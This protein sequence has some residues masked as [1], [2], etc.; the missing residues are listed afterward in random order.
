[1]ARRIVV[2]VI[3]LGVVAVGFAGGVSSPV[4]RGVMGMGNRAV[5]LFEVPGQSGNWNGEV[6]AVIPGTKWR[7]KSAT[8]NPGQVVVDVPGKGAIAL[9]QGE[10]YLG[11]AKAEKAPDVDRPQNKAA[12]EFVPPTPAQRA[13]ADRARLNAALSRAASAT[14]RPAA[15]PGEETVQGP[16]MVTTIDCSQVDLPI[17]QLGM[18]GYDTAFMVTSAAC[19]ACRKTAPSVRALAKKPQKRV[20]FLD[21]GTTPDGKINFKAPMLARRGISA[22]PHFFVVEQ[23]GHF[24][25]GNDAA[26]KMESW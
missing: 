14:R 15:A 12:A 16:S 23:S 9:K 7:I 26:T 3:A 10:T 11:G 19:G 8:L 17:E 24:L 20:V 2:L 18:Q 4:F 21:I 13:A 22:I 1:M 25:A 6:G 5:V